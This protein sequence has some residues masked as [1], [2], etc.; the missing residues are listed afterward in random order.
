MDE[1]KRSRIVLPEMLFMFFVCFFADIIEFLTAGMI[2]FIVNL[3]V[4]PIIQL[5]LFFRGGRGKWAFARQVLFGAGGVFELIPGIAALPIRTISLIIVLILT[6][7][8]S[9]FGGLAEKLEGAAAAAV[10]PAAKA[11]GA[12]TA[13]AVVK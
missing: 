6:Y 10:K 4:W 1:E 13:A 2:P 11:A 8:E 5:W 3:I 7:A 12:A 9:R